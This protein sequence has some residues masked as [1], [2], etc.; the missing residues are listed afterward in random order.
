MVEQSVP[1]HSIY[2]VVIVGGGIAGLYSAYRLLQLQ[3]E[4]KLLLVEKQAYLGGRIFTYTDDTMTVEGG[5]GR[6]TKHHSLLWRLLKEL[7]LDSKAVPISGGFTY[8]DSH[9]V[10]DGR[11]ASQSH[12]FLDGRKASEGP[13]KDIAEIVRAS[14]SETVSY[15]RSV[16]FLDFAKR[17]IGPS[18]AQ[19]IVDSFGY[20]SEL[21]IMNA[22]DA[23][24]LMDVLERPGFYALAGGLSQIIVELEKRVREYPNVEIWTKMGVQRFSM[25]GGGRRNRKTSNRH[26]MKP[27]PTSKS[28]TIRKHNPNGGVYSFELSD[29]HLVYSNRCIFAVPKQALEKLSAFRPVR[30][31]LKQIACG[32]LC[33]IYSQF[34]K[35]KLSSLDVLYEKKYTI[36]NDL[37]MII[38]ID[39]KT[40][41]VMI[42][43]TDNRFAD[44][45][46]AL[47]K[48]ES[49]EAVD[50]K[51]A[52]LVR[53]T[54]DI[55]LPKP[56]KT[57]VF[58]W[59]C[60]VGYWKVGANSL[61]VS[62]RI[63]QPFS[64]EKVYVCGEHYSEKNQQWIEGAL[65]TSERMLDRFWSF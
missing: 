65:E 13:E 41:V 11:K 24:V 55:T 36:N 10:L 60:G 25:S 45:W 4:T 14:T 6:F 49:I 40:G 56:I 50:A 59:P 53:D 42:S 54:L 23:I 22:H 32:S 63:I 26:S 37:R 57:K 48:E 17:V 52:G 16:S 51:I 27:K 43:Y 61:V 38:P 21:V 58:Y 30:P 3:P 9:K 34:P 62:K 19:H 44:E 47:E 33:R 15:L 8:I 2:D 39:R 35:D 12:K 7:E 5:A 1:K 18:R 29:G 64:G 31:L 46:H 28:K 20:Y